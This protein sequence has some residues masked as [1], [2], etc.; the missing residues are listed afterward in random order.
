MRVL[1]AV[2]DS[3][4]SKAAVQF[5]KSM[6][7]PAK[8]EFVV[9]SVAPSMYLAYS[10]GDVPGATPMV[11]QDVVK[12]WLSHHELIATRYMREIEALGLQA[13]P[14]AVSGDPRTMIL[15]TAVL[16]NSDLIVIGS[17]G[18]SGLKKILLGS[19]S[20]HVVTQAHCSVLVVKLPQ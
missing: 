11:S 6:T 1:I 7:W 10:L 12:Q 17:H 18:R 14:L 20:S 5:V 4:W 9:L 13:R 19:V 3:E 8:S 15:E 2:D 16:E